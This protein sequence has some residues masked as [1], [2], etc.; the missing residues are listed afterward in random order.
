MEGDSFISSE[1]GPDL[2]NSIYT[3]VNDSINTVMSYDEGAY[4]ENGISYHAGFYRKE[5][6]YVANLVNATAAQIGEVVF[7]NSMSGI[8]GYFATVKLSTDATTR[9]G[10]MKELFAVGS[11]FVTSSH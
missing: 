2:V 1:Q 9:V 8:K 4:T 10:G 3:N 6:R 7:G 11:N 5:N